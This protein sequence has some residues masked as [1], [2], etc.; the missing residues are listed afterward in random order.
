M[1]FQGNLLGLMANL[2]SKADDIEDFYHNIV[3]KF[4]AKLG[5]YNLR[6]LLGQVCLSLRKNPNFSKLNVDGEVMVQ[7]AN[8]LGTRRSLNV[9]EFDYN[10]ITTILVEACKNY[11]NYSTQT[12]EFFAIN[13]IFWA[14]LDEL[15]T[16]EKSLEYLELWMNSI[17]VSDRAVVLR[18]KHNILDTAIY[19]LKCH[20]GN[21]AC[22]KS[23][24]KMLDLNLDLGKK[25]D[26]EVFLL[27]YLD[28][29]GLESVD[30]KKNVNRFLDLAVDLKINNRQRAFL[31][32]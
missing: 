7:M 8:L 31:I 19:Y 17:D 28:L 22:V 23:S 12:Q 16:R 9:E 30:K 25:V 11:K 29:A 10:N 15:S 14:K 4:V 2:A 6:K 21:E 24:I 18:Y 5:N 3:I 1:E 13:C 27:P 32:V 20:F 26:P